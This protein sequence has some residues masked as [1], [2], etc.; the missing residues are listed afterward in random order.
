MA[1]GLLFI[2]N[3][4][5]EVKDVDRFSKN[6]KHRWLFGG[7]IRKIIGS[8]RYYVILGYTSQPISKSFLRTTY[9]YWL[10]CENILRVVL[11]KIHEKHV[12]SSTAWNALIQAIKPI[13]PITIRDNKRKELLSYAI[14][15][16]NLG[17]LLRRAVSVTLQY[18]LNP[19][20]VLREIRASCNEFRLQIEE[21][22]K[23][24]KFDDD[25]K[26]PTDKENWP[27]QIRTN[28]HEFP[29]DIGYI[30]FHNTILNFVLLEC[31]CNTLAYFKS[32]I[33]IDLK[34]SKRDDIDDD[35]DVDIILKISNDCDSSCEK[36]DKSGIIA[37]E[38]A[39]NAVGG[40]FTSNYDS[41]K[42]LWIAILKL[43]G[44]SVPTDLTGRWLHEYIR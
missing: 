8:E 40:E 16:I 36:G 31:L 13:H 10:K 41:T 33:C 35:R 3:D 24:L 19:K 38:K 37:C 2:S 6:T 4:A 5:G 34:F 7:E 22:V 18:E 26:I 1:E 29:E 32:R 20:A 42:G 9:Y 44:Y 25:L 21:T 14:S 28:E 17:D 30:A 23:H 39:A 12:V 11:P 27:V 43:R 15:N